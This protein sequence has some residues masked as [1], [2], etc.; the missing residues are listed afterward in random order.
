VI[1]T[2]IG[3]LF[4]NATSEGVTCLDFKPPE[5]SA[6]AVSEAERHLESVARELEE[7]FAGTLRA[8]TTPVAP[9]G[10]NFQKSVWKELGRIPYG[11]TIT[12]T[13]LTERLGN[14]LAIRAV[15]AAN[16]AN[17]ISIVVPCHRVIAAN[18]DLQGYRGGLDKKRFLIDHERGQ[19]QLF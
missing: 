16:G 9:I 18:G 19:S 11:E 14:P 3:D 17:L 1:N 6:T 2:P 12:Y 10:T 15:A 13:Q 7:Y 8:F 5:H 4:A